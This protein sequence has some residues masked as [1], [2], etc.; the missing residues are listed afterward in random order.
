MNLQSINYKILSS[1]YYSL[2]YLP[3]I[4]VGG[5]LASRHPAVEALLV[6]L[7]V[8]QDLYGLI[9]VPE[10]GV[11]AEQS[12]RGEVAQHLVKRVVPEV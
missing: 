2:F 7:D 3:D 10:E 12:D 4:V 9:V 11:K 6:E 1:G 8:L 5:D